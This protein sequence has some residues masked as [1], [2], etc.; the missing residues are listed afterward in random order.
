MSARFSRLDAACDV[1]GARKQQQ[2][3]GKRRLTGIRMRNYG[4]RATPRHLLTDHH[5]IFLMLVIRGALL[6]LVPGDK[7]N[8]AR[9]ALG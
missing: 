1:N 7:D 4:K 9:Y 2:L 5:E 8:S 6:G 3:L